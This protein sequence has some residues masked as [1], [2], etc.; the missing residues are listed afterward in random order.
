MECLSVRLFIRSEGKGEKPLNLRLCSLCTLCVAASV[1]HP[2]RR[3]WR[4]H[5]PRL[6]P[7]VP[8]IPIRPG[9]PSFRIS[10]AFSSLSGGGGGGG[11]DLRLAKEVEGGGAW[12]TG[13]GGREVSAVPGGGRE[14]KKDLSSR[15]YPLWAFGKALSLSLPLS[16]FFIHN[17][18]LFSSLLPFPPAGSLV[19]SQESLSRLL[20]G[21]EGWSSI[22]SFFKEIKS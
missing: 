19:A 21:K 8:G 12:G 10:I 18:S 16:P 15:F 17:S 3:R 9:L 14:R 20:P 1:S 7:F 11:E 6:P 22:F 2:A 4:H 13:D 5:Q